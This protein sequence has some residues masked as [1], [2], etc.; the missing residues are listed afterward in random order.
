[1]KQNFTFKHLLV[2]VGLFLS[3][4][5]TVFVAFAL[6]L[7]SLGLPERRSK[8]AFFLLLPITLFISVIV[9]YLSRRHSSKQFKAI[10]KLI[11]DYGP[12]EKCVQGIQHI[13]DQEK[14]PTLS[15][16]FKFI[17]ANI[18]ISEMADAEK[19]LKVLETVNRFEL[20][21]NNDN[22]SKSMQANYYYLLF[23]S[24]SFLGNS[25][26]VCGIYNEAFP[27]F[28]KFYDN[29]SQRLIWVSINSDYEKARG[30]YD[31]A[32]K[33]IE[34]YLKSDDYKLRTAISLDIAAIYLKTGRLE[35]TE[36]ILS[37]FDPKQNNVAM[38][39][40]YNIILD[41][42]HKAKENNPV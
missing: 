14:S 10:R 31:D 2:K 35:E 27:L 32:L 11:S 25:Q 19:S 38:N 21:K 8:I 40:I 23:I 37:E 39:K 1:M 12:G 17:L 42:L 16:L 20:F 41:K 22:Y 24:Y 18:Y 33:I 29:D 30:N 9:F 7:Y 4:W 13:I 5:A 28:K 34:P 3:I 6:V 36:K 15:N 26:V